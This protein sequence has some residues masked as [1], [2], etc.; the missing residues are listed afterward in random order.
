MARTAGGAVK[1]QV[2]GNKQLADA[3]KQ[4]RTTEVKKIARKGLRAGAKEIHR[5]TVARSP[6]GITKQLK[7]SFKVRAMKRSRNKIGVLVQSGKGFFVGDTF[8]S[9]FVA[10][11]HKVGHRR[12]GDSRK[13]VPPNEFMKEAAESA[14]PKAIEVMTATMKTE[15][16]KLITSKR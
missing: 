16:A 8:Y 7:K 14:A 1:I 12:L 5:E 3:F 15:L 11:G 13:E 10:F 6:V 2:Q 4:L 9:G